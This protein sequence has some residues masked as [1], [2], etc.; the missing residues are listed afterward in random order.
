M[1]PHPL[2]TGWTARASRALLRLVGWQGV[3]APLPG[4][5]G[6]FIIYPHTSNWDFPLGVLYRHG[7]GLEVQWMGKASL[8][9]GTLGPLM[10]ALGGIAIDRSAAQGLT[11]AILDTYRQRDTLWLAITPEGTRGKVEHLKSGFYRIAVGAGVPC[12]LAFIDYATRRVGVD[13]YV[14]FT[15]DEAR[16]LATLREYYASKRGRRPAFEGAIAFR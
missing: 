3:Y 15:G 8:F 2:P 5:K 16:D 12:G 11:A 4:P 6:V 7:A 1:P 10:R 9:R 13:T 14:T